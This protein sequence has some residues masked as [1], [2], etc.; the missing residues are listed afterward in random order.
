LTVGL[1]CRS[2]CVEILL[3]RGVTQ[4]SRVGWPGEPTVT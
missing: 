1:F 2:L 3:A 4:F